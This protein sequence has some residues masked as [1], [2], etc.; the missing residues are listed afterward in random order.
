[1]SGSSRRCVNRETRNRD[2][3]EGSDYF[4]YY[5]RFPNRANP[6]SVTPNNDGTFTIYLNTRFPLEFLADRLQHELRHIQRGHF[7]TDMPIKL[8]ERQADGERLHDDFFHPPAGMI[9]CF[10]SEEALAAFVNRLLGNW[11]N[12]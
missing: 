12:I 7:E 10:E 9:P 1:M 2:L 5:V 8:I 11:K 3:I 6:S 4:I